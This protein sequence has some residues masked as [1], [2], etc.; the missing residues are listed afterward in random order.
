[1]RQELGEEEREREGVRERVREG[2][3]EGERDRGREGGTEGGEGKRWSKTASIVSKP[4]PWYTHSKD[5]LLKQ[6]QRAS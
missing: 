3:R 2:Q 5:D 1:M 4:F 6:Q